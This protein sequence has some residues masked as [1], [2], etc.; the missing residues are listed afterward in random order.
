MA[1]Q[2]TPQSFLREITI[3]DFRAIRNVNF[4]PGRIINVLSGK[5]GSG[6]STV[7]GMIAQPFSFESLLIHDF[8]ESALPTLTDPD[9]KLRMQT[10]ISSTK[11]I[12][13]TNFQ[14]NV[15]QH[16]ELS[17]LDLPNVVHANFIFE[18]KILRSNIKINIESSNSTGRTA[19]RF[20]T[21][22][23]DYPIGTDHVDRSS[24][25]E[26]FPVIYLGLKRVT[27]IVQERVIERPSVL[28][29]AETTYFNTRYSEILLNDYDHEIKSTTTS[30]KKTH[31]PLSEGRDLKMISSGE[32]NVGQ[33]LAALI[34]FK[35]LKESYSD[36]TGGILLIDEIDATMYPGS[37][38]QLLRVLYREA[39]T[40]KLQVFI[41]SHSMYL[42]DSAIEMMKT[43]HGVNVIAMKKDQSG[44][45]SSSEK[46]SSEELWSMLHESS[47]QIKTIRNKTRLYFED[48]EAIFVFNALITKK[49]IKK[50]I[51]IVD[52]TLGCD[53]YI[54][55]REHRIPEFTNK[56]V[57]VLDGDQL[58]S[59][60]QLAQLSVG[61]RRKIQ[62]IK[63]FDNFTCL[64]SI[65]SEPPEKMIYNYISNRRLTT[66]WESTN[67][68]YTYEMF[69]QNS[70]N[71]AIKEIL[72]GTFTE[73][74]STTPPYK[75]KRVRDV[76]KM[77]FT[78]EKNHWKVVK[79]NPFRHWA[80]NNKELVLEFE[81]DFVKALNSVR[82]ENGEPPLS[83]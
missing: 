29:A 22:K 2:S 45:V 36:Y 10:L 19:P 31:A 64:P 12:Y 24:S 41:T 83:L 67:S 3:K 34:S 39:A 75:N 60:E 38:K 55:L 56:A 17:P 20:V 9:E 74:L 32:D 4:K 54:Q 46:I 73:S 63:S 52:A 35:R 66:F 26:V 15:N 37:Q 14:S 72:H 48:G 58:V 33:I 8:P 50:D 62:K 5:N 23:P 7:L 21:R 40:L 78:E 59:D 53:S 51:K 43:T 27:P 49:I 71:T 65:N 61:D 77:W 13:N 57:V 47:P 44:L 16:F 82:K 18:H 70:H 76:W 25:N 11:T 28:T 81:K 42:I 68:Q 6:K 80:E 30:N 69:M 1:N 79:N